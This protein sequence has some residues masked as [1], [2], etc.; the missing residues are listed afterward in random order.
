MSRQSI[1]VT[2]VIA[3]LGLLLVARAMVGH[4]MGRVYSETR[5]VDM[6]EV[7]VPSMDPMSVDEDKVRAGEMVTVPTWIEVDD[8]EELERLRGEGRKVVS[9]TVR[10]PV[11]A[12]EVLADPANATATLDWSRTLGIWLAAF[13]TLAI[14]SFL[15]KDNPIYK[16]AESIVVGISAAYA[17]V[18]GFWDM[19]VPNL[20][21]KLTPT[22]VQNHFQPGLTDV[23]PQ[24][25][26]LIPAIFGVLLLMRLAPKGQWLSLWT[27]AF[28]VGTT[29]AIRMVGY[30]ESD[31][32]TQI[33]QT[34]EP[35]YQVVE[36]PDGTVNGYST[37]WASAR[38]FTLV[39]GV[40]TCLTYFFFSVEHKGGVGKVARVGIWFLM[41]TFGAAFGFTVMGRIA[42]L[43][44]RFE[45]L[46]DDW[47]WIID[48]SGQRV[49]ATA[50]SMIM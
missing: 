1:A 40:L 24:W 45:F 26:Y 44:A 46:F 35:V 7:D 50:A 18:V 19:I 4:G 25:V 27:L 5:S 30:I 29:A 13:F 10:E 16:T 20:L 3:V 48:P 14:F 38:Q 31:F 43:A 33:K 12:R 8:P 2:V 41:I 42:L 21:G 37:F 39:V 32:L 36:N 9:W 15:Y 28:I 11:P 34:L 22:L 23:D 17:M 47:L 6:V 49:V